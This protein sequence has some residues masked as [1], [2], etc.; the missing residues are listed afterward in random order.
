[1]PVTIHDRTMTSDRTPHAARLA[2][3]TQH[4]ATTAMTL[5]KACG[6]AAPP[7]RNRLWPRIQGRAW[8][9]A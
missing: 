1:M 7:E 2:P 5:A 6:A 9:G 3:G 4:Q 8:A